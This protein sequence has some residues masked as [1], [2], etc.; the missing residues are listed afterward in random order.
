MLAW[1]YFEFT[2]LMFWWELGRH[3]W[4][5]GW[6]H[7]FFSLFFFFFFFFFFSCKQT[8]DFTSFFFFPFS[9]FFFK[10]K[11]RFW[12][13]L[14][15]R[16]IPTYL[17]R[18]KLFLFVLFLLLFFS[19]SHSSVPAVHLITTVYTNCCQRNER[20]CVREGGWG[21]TALIRLSFGRTAREGEC[22][23]VLRPFISDLLLYILLLIYNRLG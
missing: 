10:A 23:A 3:N 12:C 18:P 9:F 13:W 6:P 5:T 1:F 2:A 21:V 19:P 8:H 11:Y 4:K 20:M 7:S 22:V 17:L 15:S 16:M 14:G